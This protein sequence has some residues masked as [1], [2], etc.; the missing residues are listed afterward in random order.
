MKLVIDEYKD[1]V[2]AIPGLFQFNSNEQFTQSVLT[3]T[4]K[5]LLFY[6]DNAPSDV[7]GETY[8]Y[9]VKK[10][11]NLDDVCFVINEKIIKNKELANLGRFNFILEEEENCFEFY[12]FLNDKKEVQDF[13]KMMKREGIKVKK[14]KIDLSLKKY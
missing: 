5:E 9:V 11:V 1:A 7:S 13:I 14:R 10:R 8:H 3:L 6:D 2:A 4:E 12:Y